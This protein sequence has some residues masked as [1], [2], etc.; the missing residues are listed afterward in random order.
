MKMIT[1]FVV[2]YVPYGIQIQSS[3]SYDWSEDLQC[4]FSYTW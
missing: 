3:A 2:L 4:L 1:L